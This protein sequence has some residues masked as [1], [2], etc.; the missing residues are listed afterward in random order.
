VQSQLGARLARTMPVSGGSLGLEASLAW[1]HAFQ[2]VTPTA[3]ESFAGVAGTDFNL[4]GVNTGRDGAR[5]RAG[6]TY[7]TRHIAFFARYEG[8]VSDRETQN[9]ITGGVRVAF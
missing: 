3:A 4:A 6:L 9:A 2:S 7:T 5:V 1:T 8:D